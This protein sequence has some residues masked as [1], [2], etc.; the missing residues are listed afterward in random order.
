M[1]EDKEKF[2]HLYRAV[3]STMEVA[4]TRE[5]SAD[6]ASSAMVQAASHLEAKINKLIE[7]GNNCYESVS[8]WAPAK[9]FLIVMIVGVSTLT[10]STII[11]RNMLPSQAEIQERFE[12]KKQLDSYISKNKV[13]LRNCDGRRCVKINKDELK[14]ENTYGSDDEVYVI[15]DGQ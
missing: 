10:V 14:N 3:T 12:Y 9:L 8:L 11:L 1:C 7:R 2:E 13:I 6:R 5:E 4:R 15:L